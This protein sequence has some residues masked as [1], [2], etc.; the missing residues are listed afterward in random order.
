MYR[1]IWAEREK[2]THPNYIIYHSRKYSLEDLQQRF[3]ESTGLWIYN[4][5]RGDD[6][7]EGMTS[8]KSL[9]TCGFFF[10]LRHHLF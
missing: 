3:G 5:V 7:E 4:I 2:A 8:K 10:L 1:N 9:I 6:D